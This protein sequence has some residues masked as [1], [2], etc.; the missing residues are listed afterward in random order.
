MSTKWEYMA[1]QTCHLHSN[2]LFFFLDLLQSCIQSFLL[3]KC[4]RKHP[5]RQWKYWVQKSWR[6]GE[7]ITAFGSNNF[8]NIFTIQLKVLYDGSNF[9]ITHRVVELERYMSM[10]E[11]NGFI[12]RFITWPLEARGLD[13]KMIIHPDYR[14]LRVKISNMQ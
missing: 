2:Y 10:K 8:T 4:R 6:C 14:L 9:T 3:R 13:R 1:A 12:L 5:T 11:R 7:Y